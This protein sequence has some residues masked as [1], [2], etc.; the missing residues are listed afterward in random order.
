[1]NIQ[2][3]SYQD[4]ELLMNALIF[5]RHSQEKIEEIR[6][7]IPSTADKM[8]RENAAWHN[9]YMKIVNRKSNADVISVNGIS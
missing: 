5:A 6:R 1:M 8:E 9:L 3:D 7:I 4:A 2:F